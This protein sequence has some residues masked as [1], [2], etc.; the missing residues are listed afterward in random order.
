M[1]IP[2]HPDY[3]Q[4]E[5]NVACNAECPFCPQNE[6]VRRPKTMRNDVWKKIVDETRG[7]GITYRPFLVNEPLTD[8]RLGEIMR[9]IRRDDTAKIELNT[10]G[11][12]LD[13]EFALEILDAGIDVMRFSI[14][15]YS[16]ETFSRARIGLDFRKTIDRTLDFVR[17][18]RE[19]NGANRIE[20]RMIETE[21]T[22]PEID[23]FKKFWKKAGA[24]PVIT[25]LYHWPWEP[26]VRSVQLPCIKVLKEMFFL[27][28]GKATLC[29]WDTHERAI[30][31]DVTREHTLDIWTG[32]IN[33]RFRSLLAEGRRDQI[34][35][36]SRCDAYKD[37]EFE[38]FPSYAS[39]G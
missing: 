8:R 33:R 28:N 2:A 23:D 6:L 11:E 4:I 36:C 12:L 20:V 7:L 29:C 37:R 38:G 9:Y 31:G 34:L 22:R 32:A 27:V 21:E 26:G 35:L 15:G 25:T 5:T 1:D 10:N 30:I 17:L 39:Q 13:R 24:E 16:E 14:D 3:I 19:R 18:A